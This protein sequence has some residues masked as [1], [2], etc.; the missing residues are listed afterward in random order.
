M[1][2]LPIGLAVAGL[3]LAPTTVGAQGAP[4]DYCLAVNPVQ[5]QCSF[6]VQD[7]ATTPVTGAA[8]RGD[9]VVIVKRG[10]VKTK[11]TSPASGEPTAI[12][13]TM[14]AGDKVTAKALSPGSGVLTG[15]L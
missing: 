4:N 3:V 7:T 14:V 8:G 9:W 10:K 1:R 12:S 6:T 15:D 5:P 13:F 11:L 2:R